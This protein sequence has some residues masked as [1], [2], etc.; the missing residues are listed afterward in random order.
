VRPTWEQTGLG[1]DDEPVDAYGTPLSLVESLRQAQEDMIALPE[2]APEEL[3]EEELI[4]AS[5]LEEPVPETKAIAQTTIFDFTGEAQSGVEL[6]PE[7]P[8]ETQPLAEPV[9]EAQPEPELEPENEIEI[10]LGEEPEMVLQPQAAPADRA[11]KSHAVDPDR[12]K[13]LAEAGCLFVERGRV[14]VSMLQRQY[15]MDF[16]D[17]CKVLDELQDLGLIG[18]YLGGQ[19]RDILLTRDQWLEKA[20]A[21]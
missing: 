20:G 2:S 4:P 11:H 15:G 10:E 18:P 21:I 6:F 5:E 17:A 12:A 16:D 8:K 1:E 3:E 7:E 9:A 19:S 13:F 14:A